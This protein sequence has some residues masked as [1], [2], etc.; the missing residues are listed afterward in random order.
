M[1]KYI[2]ITLTGIYLIG[3]WLLPTLGLDELLPFQFII[4]GILIKIAY[5]VAKTVMW[6][7]ILACIIQILIYLYSNPLANPL[8]ITI[9]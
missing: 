9:F 2:L 5:K 1:N 4:A 6:I 7:I 3:G 8:I